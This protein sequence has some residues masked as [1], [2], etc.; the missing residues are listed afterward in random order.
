M[1]KESQK[2]PEKK[3]FKL[4]ILKVL[5]AVLLII[6]FGKFA[7]QIAK[8][9]KLKRFVKN[10]K[11]E[12]KELVD[13][14]EDF[15]RFWSD[16]KELL[17]NSFI[18]NDSNDHR[19][20]ILRPKSLATIAVVAVT[21]KL[22][23]TGLLFTAYP[24]QAQLA[25]IVSSNMIRLTNQ[26]RAEAGLPPL[27]ES[28]ALASFA[29]IKGED[30]IERNYFAHDTPDGKRPWEWIDRGEYD[31][32]YAGENL[33]MDFVTA[34]VVHEA[35]MKSPSHRRNIL[36]PNYQ[37]IGVAV[38]KGEIDGHQTI[39]LVN[40]FGS[41]RANTAPIATTQEPSDL[42]PVEA[43]QDTPSN[44]AGVEA[45]VEPIPQNIAAENPELG[46]EGSHPG[47]IVVT[48]K[49]TNARALV[50]WVVEYSNIFFIAFLIFM[51]ISLA[52]NVFVKV[53]VQHASV[54]LQSSVVIALLI[55]LLLVKFHFVEKV[56]SQ[57]LIL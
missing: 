39:L 9:G 49:D 25:A 4:R 13:G 11:R 37:D 33:A 46:V 1:S 51:L 41:E 32:I 53:Q 17:K 15:N 14:E 55:A 26:S 16:S 35:F 18:P 28:S 45:P 42:E 47:I 43:D 34:E 2:K 38:L 21:L 20:K 10:E 29:K 54:I 22:A 19:P 44:V 48:T 6:R 40:F 12:L 30:M 56:A 52:L 8:T 5:G 23:V 36:N 57:L 27:N 3:H 24:N 7:S 31:Y 50:D